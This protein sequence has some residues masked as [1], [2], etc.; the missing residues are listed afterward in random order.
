MRGCGF[1]RSY[2]FPQGRE[3]DP[4][5]CD[6]RDGREKRYGEGALSVDADHEHCESEQHR[7]A[8]RDESGDE[9]VGGDGGTQGQDYSP[10]EKNEHWRAVLESNAASNEEYGRA[11]KR[12]PYPPIDSWRGVKKDSGAE[13][14]GG[15]GANPNGSGRG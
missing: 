3:P 10:A 13:E 12:D 11:G 4:K 7:D 1:G 6:K 14:S 9:F 2:G 5:N 8:H 15:E